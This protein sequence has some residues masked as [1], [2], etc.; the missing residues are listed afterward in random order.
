MDVA[1]GALLGQAGVIRTDTIE[2]LFDV[3]ALLANQPA[4]KGNRLAILTN[5]GGP[6]I[7]AAD[8]AEANGVALPA[9]ASSTVEVLRRLLPP[10]ASLRNPVDMIASARAEAYEI[11]LRELLADDGV[12]AALVIYVP[13]LVTKPAEVAA[14]IARASRGAEK[15]ILTCMLGDEGVSGALAT[16]REAHL[17]VYRFPENAVI[18]FGRAAGHGRWLQRPEGKRLALPDG[19]AVRAR[20]AALLAKAPAPPSGWLDADTTRGVLEAYGLRTPRAALAATADDAVRIAGE[21]GGPVALK[22]ASPTITHKTDVGGV[23]LDLRTP[24][25]VR[26]ACR[27]MLERLATLGRRDE[28]TGFLVQEMVGAGAGAGAGVET[29][30]ETFVGLTEAQNFGSLIAFGLGGTDLELQRDVVF[31]VN[32]ITDVDAREMLD[33]LRG[34]ARLGAF[35]GRPAVD[36]AALV[37]AILRVSRLAEDVPGIAELDLN[38]LVAFPAGRGVIA[39]DARIRVRR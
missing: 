28:V 29:G 10:E 5:A 1:T 24:V 4:P 2:Q 38:P 12:D 7:M 16:L 21:F 35:R 8:A 13:P 26:E 25:E 30:V 37:D 22:V 11:A 14:A 18:A 17:P 39:V 6:G 20:V 3:A 19:E 32:P 15:P 33:E 27:A 36:R 34:A 9:L 23:A 31:R